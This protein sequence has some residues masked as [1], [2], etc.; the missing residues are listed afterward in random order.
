MSGTIMS[1]VHRDGNKKAYRQLQ[2]VDLVVDTMYV[3]TTRGYRV[4]GVVAVRRTVADRDAPPHCDTYELLVNGTVVA[5]QT[6]RRD[7]ETGRPRE[8]I[9]NVVARIEEIT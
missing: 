1:E 4:L 6:Y 2:C 5:I 3:N 8:L 9:R 7:V